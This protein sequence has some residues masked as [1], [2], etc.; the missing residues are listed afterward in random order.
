VVSPVL[1]SSRVSVTRIWIID[2]RAVNRSILAELAGALEPAAEVR[3]F[4]TARDALAAALRDIPDLVVTDYKM[5]EMDGAAFVSHFR[6]LPGCADVPTVVVTAYDDR[7]LRYAALEAGATDFLA[8]P[9]DHREF[10]VRARN[11]L[12]IRRQKLTIEARAEQLAEELD[13]SVARLRAVADTVPAMISATDANGRIVFANDVFVETLGTTKEDVVGQTADTLLGTLYADETAA[14]DAAVL[15]EGRRY[16]PYLERVDLGGTKRTLLTSKSPVPDAKGRPMHVVTVS[17]DTTALGRSSPNT[18]QNAALRALAD[19]IPDFALILDRD[20]RAT[21][22]NRALAEAVGRPPGELVGRRAT[23]FLARPEERDAFLQDLRNAGL[24]RCSPVRP[25]TSL[26]G[27]KRTLVWEF[28]EVAVP[29]GSAILALAR[30][31]ASDSEAAQA[32]REHSALLRT[33]KAELQHPL[34]E[35]VDV[36]GILRSGALTAGDPRYASYLDRLHETALRLVAKLRDALDVGEVSSFRLDEANVHLVGTVMRAVRRAERDPDTTGRIVVDLPPSLPTV[37][38][39]EEKFERAIFALV[40]HVMH[41]T[42][43]GS[44]VLISAAVHGD[45]GIG[46]QVAG[47][48]EMPV[49]Y[50]GAR[51]VRPTVLTEAA[52]RPVEHE[53]TL[54]DSAEASRRRAVQA[55]PVSVIPAAT[56]ATTEVW[57]VDPSLAVAA[58]LVRL[59]GGEIVFARPDEGGRTAELRLPRERTVHAF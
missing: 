28:R 57:T 18:E 14:I 9:V 16:A 1:S 37:R 24:E 47:V 59:H 49:E 50:A 52:V 51:A 11:L 31:S 8:S 45:G 17:L 35:I 19:L 58:E 53:P 32:A 15:R 7:E 30:T 46:L 38:I 20:G 42:P 12:T 4:E 40:T 44:M 41:V 3:A 56:R 5:P 23:D 25:F 36:S 2:D 55:V 33:T 22:V 54:D 39:D 10:A 48:A 43:R 27:T 29:S 26:D 13:S 6:A 34:K 21:F